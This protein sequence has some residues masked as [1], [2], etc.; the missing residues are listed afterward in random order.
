M[1][2]ENAPGF[3]LPLS[4]GSNGYS[5]VISVLEQYGESSSLN[6]NQEV[7]QVC[8]R[9]S[10]RHRGLDRLRPQSAP[11]RVGPTQPSRFIPIG[12]P[13]KRWYRR[14]SG[15]LMHPLIVTFKRVL[16]KLAGR[17]TAEGGLVKVDAHAPQKPYDEL[18]SGQRSWWSGFP[19][20]TDSH[21]EFAKW[22][23]HWMSRIPDPSGDHDQ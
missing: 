6:P 9:F 13:A 12:I 10:V 15:R 2:E 11:P 4:Y 23:N 17:N 5:R 7:S 8:A 22:W 1:L 14:I 18:R 19:F 16:G 3:P 21:D 20:R